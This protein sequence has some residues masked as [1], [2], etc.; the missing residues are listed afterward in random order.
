[1]GAAWVEA[2]AQKKLDVKFGEWE[3]FHAGCFVNA[4]HGSAALVDRVTEEVTMSPAFHEWNGEK[5]RTGPV[6]EKDGKTDVTWV[7]LP[8]HEGEPALQSGVKVQAQ[9]ES[10]SAPEGANARNGIDKERTP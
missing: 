3:C 6:E 4:R 7:L 1:V 2:V 10:S 8:P 9:N 5:I